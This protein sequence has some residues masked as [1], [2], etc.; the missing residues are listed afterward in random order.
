MQEL[1]LTERAIVKLN[2]IALELHYVE[3]QRKMN[4]L[5]DRLS[6]SRDYHR[7]NKRKRIDCLRSI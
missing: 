7:E 4:R 6:G 1:T 3:V 5:V 2:H